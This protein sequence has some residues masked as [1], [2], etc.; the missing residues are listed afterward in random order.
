MGE[1]RKYGKH[2]YWTEAEEK[3]LRRLSLTKTSY[4]IAEIMGR[5][6]SSIDCKRERMGISDC[7]N[8]TD[9]IIARQVGKLVGQH[10]KSVYNR[11]KKAGLPLKQLGAK[12]Y[13]ISEKELVKFMQ[14]HHELWR[15]SQCDYYFFC[16]YDWF[17]ERLKKER[18]GTDTINHYRNRRPWTTY[19]LS[20]AKML[21]NKGLHYTEIAK[22]LGRSDMAAYHIVKKFRKE[23]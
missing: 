4:Q 7:K 5:T 2:K 20:R 3:Q 21:Y 22:E 10:E 11:W 12:Y 23:E 6:K 16:K 14:E 19:E 18:N 1:I 8:N 13:S 17:L 9:N 15:A